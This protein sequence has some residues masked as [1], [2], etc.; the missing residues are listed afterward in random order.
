[1]FS[2][3]SVCHD[4]GAGPSSSSLPHW[5]SFSIKPQ[6]HHPSAH[7]DFK[8]ANLRWG[9][10]GHN[11]PHGMTHPEGALLHDCYVL[12]PFRPSPAPVILADILAIISFWNA[13]RL[14]SKTTRVDGSTS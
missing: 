2:M 6:T 11:T 7:A 13:R 9:A 3:I 10:L 4:Q 1:M 8:T 14:G 5:A 12:L